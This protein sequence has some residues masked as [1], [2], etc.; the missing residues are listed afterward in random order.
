MVHFPSTHNIAD[1]IT[2]TQDI[3]L[4][5]NPKISSLLDIGGTDFF[6]FSKTQS[7]SYTSINLETPLQ[8]GTGGYKKL[9]TTLTYDGR[10]LPFTKDSF[11]LVLV[12]FVFHHASNNTLF[13][14]NQIKDISS[15]YILIGEDLSELEYDTKWHNRNH[16]H[17]PGGLYRSDEEWKTLFLLFGLKLITQF[18]IHRDDDINKNHIYR[19]LY[20]LEK[21]S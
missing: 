21:K 13:L 18:I 9:P 17:Q 3:I 6:G 4:S 15:R 2:R 1:R 19:C 5:L 20:L 12:N 11:E 8:S 10:N 7:I 14:L 16:H